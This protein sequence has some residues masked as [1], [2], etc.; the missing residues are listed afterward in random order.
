MEECCESKITDLSLQKLLLGEYGSIKVVHIL[1]AISVT[2]QTA[3]PGARIRVKLRFATKSLCKFECLLVRH[4]KCREEPLRKRW[5]GA[6][7]RSGVR[8]GYPAPRHE[9]VDAVLGPT[10]HEAGQ[11]FGHVGQ[12]IDFIKFAGLDQ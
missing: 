8:F 11:Q 12:R 9:F 6:L 2:L 4:N 1:V 3:C 5:V 10:V 7:S